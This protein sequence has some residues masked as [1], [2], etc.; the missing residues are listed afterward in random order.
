MKTALVLGAGGFIGSH[1]VKKLKS[2]GFWVRGV[3]LKYP[4]YSK[5]HADHF[6]IGDLRDRDLVSHVMFSPTQKSVSDYENAFDEVY[7]LAAD[8]GGAAYIFGEGEHDADI[9]Y[10]SSLINLN[11]V[12]ESIEKKIKKI[13]YSSSACIYPEFNQLD[14]NNPICEESSAYP[15]QPDSEYGW[16]KIFSERLYLA[17]RRNFKLNIRIARFHNI[18]GP[19]GTWRGGKEKAPAAIC[20]KVASVEN[21]GSIEIWG[22]GKQTR[23]FLYIDECLEGV[24]KLMDSEFIGP[25]NIGSEEMVEINELARMAIAISGKEVNISNIPGPTGVRGRNSDNRLCIK[26]LNWEPSLKLAE[27]LKR[28]YEWINSQVQ[29]T[30]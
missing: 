21:G 30:T 11:V 7:Q 9:M 8:M 10:N 5:T 26:E 24:R 14:P 25:I 23:S 22:D 28:T 20:R 18:F 19:E 15:A 27:G 3:D 16:E 13:F 17:H 1:L 4:E 29:L 12:R 6:V 2:E